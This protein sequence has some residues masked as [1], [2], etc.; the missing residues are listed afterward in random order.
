MNGQ[1]SSP[2]NQL[3]GSSPT[4]QEYDGYIGSPSNQVYNS[5]NSYM[6]SPSD[7]VYGG[8]QIYGGNSYVGSPTASNGQSYVNSPNS[9]QFVNSPVVNTNEISSSTGL[10]LT[11]YLSPIT[12]PSPTS[13]YTGTNDLLFPP[14]STFTNQEPSYS[15][16]TS[17][18][19]DDVILT[20][21][22]VTQFYQL[23]PDL[24]FLTDAVE[25]PHSTQPQKKIKKSTVK[26]TTPSG[27]KAK[28]HKCPY[29]QH[30]SNRANN[31]REHIQIHDPNRPKPHTCKLCRKS[32]A[33]K[34][35]MN[36]HVI[37]CKNSKKKA[38]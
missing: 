26:S 13:S 30:T 14:S 37:S 17:P 10:G 29:C 36:R 7:Q 34:H 8:N 16:P 19:P 27:R 38:L 6:G 25:P 3:Y 33:R 31:M 2:I 23:Q 12:T 1:V 28:I 4:T 32:F 24:T 35:D 22:E 9:S 20:A 5:G 11:T 21:S 15:R 18:F